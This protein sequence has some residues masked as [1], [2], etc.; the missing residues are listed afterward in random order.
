MRDKEK[1]RILELIR[2]ADRL[3]ETNPTEGVRC[4][5][6]ADLIYEGFGYDSEIE[7]AI[8]RSVLGYSPLLLGAI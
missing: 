8:N 4:L 3:K 5:S 6:T 2:D 1:S 7:R